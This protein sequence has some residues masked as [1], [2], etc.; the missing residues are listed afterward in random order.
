M[1]I[2]M[3]N[4]QYLRNVFIKRKEIKENYVKHYTTKVIETK[5]GEIIALDGFGY[6]DRWYIW[7]FKHE[8]RLNL[9]IYGRQ[10]KRHNGNYIFIAKDGNGDILIPKMSADIMGLGRYEDVTKFYLKPLLKQI[11]YKS[12]NDLLKD[13]LVIYEGGIIGNADS[14]KAE[15][16]PL[17]HEL[18]YDK[19]DYTITLYTG[20][21][22]VYSD[23][24]DVYGNYYFVVHLV[25]RFCET[26]RVLRF[27]G[28]TKDIEG[29]IPPLRCEKERLDPWRTISKIE[30]TQK[31]DWIRITNREWCG[32]WSESEKKL[33][34]LEE[35]LKQMLRKGL[36][37]S[38][39]T[40]IAYSSNIFVNYID[41]F[42]KPKILPKK[43]TFELMKDLVNKIQIL[44]IKE[45]FENIF[46]L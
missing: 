13:A 16:F 26:L 24:I 31:S 43:E 33:Y 37:D 5:D 22:E 15:Y 35:T 10:P 1:V 2:D 42:I 6:T 17:L 27:L 39:A 19:P 4:G 12:V 11:D 18:S 7:Q 29:I 41:F 25:D 44:E 32:A 3:G 34:E 14:Y 9:E 45:I 8:K 40:V 36:L 21:G 20:E 23:I 46:H 38:L 28:Y 30:Q